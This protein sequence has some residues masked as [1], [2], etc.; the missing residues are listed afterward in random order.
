MNFIKLY[1]KEFMKDR[2]SFVITIAIITAMMLFLYSRTGHWTPGLPTAILA[3]AMFGFSIAAFISS[4]DCMGDEW[5]HNNHYLMLSLPVRGRDILGAKLAWFVTEFGTYML[6]LGACI[7]FVLLGEARGIGT[8][9]N[10]LYSAITVA[11][12]RT[13]GIMVLPVLYILAATGMLALSSYTVGSTVKRFKFWVGAISFIVP[14]GLL[15]YLSNKVMEISPAWMHVE[16]PLADILAWQKIENALNSN[17]VVSAGLTS[18]IN[19]TVVGVDVLALL[20]WT[21][22]FVGLFFMASWL[23]ENVVEA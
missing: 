13:Y 15:F 17:G 16:M 6:L 21:I 1:K 19:G 11:A 12:W 3:V 10:A 5:E 2:K 7:I 23:L 8:I 4:F 14:V 22:G 20:I 9:N 18:F